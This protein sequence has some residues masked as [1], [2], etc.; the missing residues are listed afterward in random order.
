[1]KDGDDLVGRVADMPVGTQATLTVDRNG[2]KMDLKLTIQDRTKVF[3]DDPRVVGENGGPSGGAD[4]PET[5]QVRFGISIRPASDEEK[6]ATPDKRGIVVTR[7]EPG[8]FADDIGLMEH[9]LIIAINRDAIASVDD[10]RRIQQGLKAGDP[11]AFRV[12]RTPQGARR[13]PSGSAPRSVTLFL[14]GTLPN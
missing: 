3:S 4:K 7:V 9:D 10:I 13:N 11:V 8:S 5:S 1:V 6:E 14:S 12:V 2:K